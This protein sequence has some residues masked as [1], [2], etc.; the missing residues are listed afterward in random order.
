VQD[1]A[2]AVALARVGDSDALAAAADQRAGVAHLAAAQRIE[3]RPVELDAA[4]VDGDDPRLCAL[5]IGIVAKEKLG[6]YIGKTKNVAC[7][8]GEAG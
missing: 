4:F 1:A 2:R 8:A 7:G 6:A 5:Q 3:D